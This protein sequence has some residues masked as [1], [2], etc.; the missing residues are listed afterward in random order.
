MFSQLMV[1]DII[2]TDIGEQL[3]KNELFLSGRYFGTVAKA[4]LYKMQRRET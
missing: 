3:S 1:V 4:V 2:S